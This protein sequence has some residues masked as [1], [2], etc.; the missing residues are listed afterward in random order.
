[1]VPETIEGS[2]M[3]A[4]HALSLVGVPMKRVIR[5]VQ[6]QRNKRYAL[7]KDFDRGSEVED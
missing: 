6:E 3:L 1:V 7:L 5:M 4:T 2:L